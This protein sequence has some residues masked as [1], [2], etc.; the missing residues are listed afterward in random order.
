MPVSKKVAATVV[1]PQTTS[2]Q[3][4]LAELV[5]LRRATPPAPTDATRASLAER[6]LLPPFSVLDARQGYWQKRKKMWLA[7]GIQSELGRG[8]GAN[9]QS[10]MALRLAGGF[11]DHPAHRAKLGNGL[12]GFSEQ[13]RSHYANATPTGR[14]FPSASIRPGEECGTPNEKYARGDGRGRPL[15]Q[16]FGSGGPGDLAAG[17]AARGAHLESGGRTGKNSAY[18]FKTQDGYR[19]LKDIQA[20]G[21]ATGSKPDNRAIKDHA[22]LAA[23]G[24]K[25]P[26][27]GIETPDLTDTETPSLPDGLTYGTTIHPYD[28]SS[29]QVQSGT[30]IF[31]PVICELAYRWFTPPGGAVLDPFAGGSVR[32]VVAARLGRSYAG[33]DLRPEQAEANR[34]QGD[35]LC[36]GADLRWVVGD[37]RGISTLLPGSYDFVFSCPPYFDLERYSD[38]PRDLST[39]GYDGFLRVYGD[40]IRQSCAMLKDDRFA[41]FVVGDVRDRAT[42]NYRNFVGDT[43]RLFREAGLE[44]YNDAVLVTAVGSLPIRVGKQFAGYRKL[45]K[46]HQNVLVF[47]K[48]DA[49]RAA[50]ACG[51]VDV[52]DLAMPGYVEGGAVLCRADAAGTVAEPY[53]MGGGAEEVDVGHVYLPP[54]ESYLLC[55]VVRGRARAAGRPVPRCWVGVGG[56][57]QRVDDA[58]DLTY[59]VGDVVYLDQAVFP[60][61]VGPSAA[62]PPVRKMRGA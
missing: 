38:D 8:E 24:K 1:E 56:G 49:G 27:A 51:E 41:C 20:D 29:S 48:G 59:L 61:A 15:A 6:F 58:A 57:W 4:T 54:T 30:S 60:E 32:G 31:D 7:L 46:T 21:E 26:Q 40:I 11:E 62:P 12:L 3:L 16:T 53:L 34:A 52:D 36:P 25:I 22:W 14:A 19:S 5:E 47:V 43:V 9:S 28:G 17:F 13:A 37:S 10:E 35:A 50:K 39:M 23:H 42:G 33:V 18:L 55:D 2:R 45:G 44:L